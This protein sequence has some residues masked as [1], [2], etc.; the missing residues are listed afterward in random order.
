MESAWVGRDS[1]YNPKNEKLR[2]ARQVLTKTLRVNAIL[3]VKAYKK[4]KKR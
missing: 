3:V 1:T 2:N 4:V